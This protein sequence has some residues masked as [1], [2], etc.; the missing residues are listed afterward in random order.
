MIA[1][2]SSANTFFSS[3]F[4]SALIGVIGTL[5]GT[6]LG[7]FLNNQSKKGKIDIHIQKWEFNLNGF[8]D[9]VISG[10]TSIKEIAE[11]G[12]V[13][14]GCEYKMKLDIYNDSEYN[15]PLRDIKVVFASDNEDLCSMIP[16]DISYG[17]KH[18]ETAPINIPPK[19]DREFCLGKS[20]LKDECEYMKQVTHVFIDYF[21]EKGKKKRVLVIKESFKEKFEKN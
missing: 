3:P 5:L 14:Y 10:Y 2:S 13:Y 11:K 8:I 1:T 15:K 7:W 16:N 21:D 9:G 20:I 6:L 4:S 18:L 17:S 12:A 19:S